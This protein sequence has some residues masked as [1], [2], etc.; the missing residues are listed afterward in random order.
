MAPA[1]PPPSA[2]PL[3]RVVDPLA[4][5]DSA[6]ALDTS[7]AEQK[8]AATTLSS[9]LIPWP[10]YGAGTESTA[11]TVVGPQ[12]VAYARHDRACVASAVGFDSRSSAPVAPEAYLEDGVGGTR[13]ASPLGAMSPPLRRFGKASMDGNG[14]ASDARTN[15]AGKGASEA[16]RHVTRGLAPREERA[17]RTPSLSRGIFSPADPSNVTTALPR[18]QPGG[19]PPGPSWAKGARTAEEPASLQFNQLDAEPTNSSPIE[20]EIGIPSQNGED[21]A[22]TAD[23]PA[24]FR[25]GQGCAPNRRWFREEMAPSRVDGA[26]Q[27]GERAVPSADGSEALPRK[28][29]GTEPEAVP[30]PHVEKAATVQERTVLR[31]EQR[32][33]ESA[34]GSYVGGGRAREEEPAVLK[35]GQADAVLTNPSA[36]GVT[37][38]TSPTEGGVA[39]PEGPTRWGSRQAGAGPSKSSPMEAMAVSVAGTSGGNAGDVFGRQDQGRLSYRDGVEAMDVDRRTLPFGETASGDPQQDG[40]ISGGRVGRGAGPT[41][42][43]IAKNVHEEGTPPLAERVVEGLASTAKTP[44]AGVPLTVPSATAEAYDN[45]TPAPEPWTEQSSVGLSS[46]GGRP[47]NMAESNLVGR[48]RA[49]ARAPGEITSP[50]TAAGVE[51]VVDAS[52]AFGRLHEDDARSLIGAMAVAP[53]TVGPVGSGSIGAASEE[54]GVGSQ[55]FGGACAGEWGMASA[56]DTASAPLDVNVS[57][58]SG[59]GAQGTFFDGRLSPVQHA[60]SMASSLSVRTRAAAEPQFSTAV[61]GHRT[62]ASMEPAVAVTMGQRSVLAPSTTSSPASSAALAGLTPAAAHAVMASSGAAPSTRPMPTAPGSG[63][64]GP[65][66]LPTSRQQPSPLVGGG[67]GDFSLYSSNGTI[68]RGGEARLSDAGPEVD[69]NG[70]SPRFARLSGERMGP[71]GSSPLTV[72]PPS[73]GSSGGMVR[74]G[75]DNGFFPR[76]SSP[77]APSGGVS[78]P[79]FGGGATAVRFSDPPVVR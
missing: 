55:R 68:A 5:R 72:R 29:S 73:R 40:R 28:S 37:W 71:V 14:E 66:G 60:A 79:R 52:S 3:S 56:R 77:I 2:A 32:G 64:A 58:I 45:P 61:T 36:A 11:R 59:P 44:A 63:Q 57:R 18:E 6:V 26:R 42:T 70:G 50:P 23:G 20:A 8:E 53:P 51:A 43:G 39:R 41:S 54:V 25:S 78:L 12:R 75:R 4:A 49:L 13:G 22:R 30:R 19:K 10:Q 76:P 7:T 16:S 17:E 9:P 15:L 27:V 24:A 34:V 47:V 46:T 33:E 31:A 74:E 65:T 62:L 35:S 1:L 21:G 48:G 67:T 38:A 69:H